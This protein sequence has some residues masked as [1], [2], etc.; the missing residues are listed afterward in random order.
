MRPS[1][2]TET[3]NAQ[4]RENRLKPGVGEETKKEFAHDDNWNHINISPLGRDEP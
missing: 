1:T 4:D 2:F 3:V